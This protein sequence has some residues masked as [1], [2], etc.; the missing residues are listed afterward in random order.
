MAFVHVRC[1]QRWRKERV[2]RAYTCEICN[3]SYNISRP[4]W[5]SIIG[6]RILAAFLALLTIFGIL[7]AMAYIVKVIDLYGFHHTPKPE[8]LDWQKWHGTSQF[9]WLDRFY[10]LV[11]LLIVAF[12]GFIA[13]GIMSCAPVQY[14]WGIAPPSMSMAA[15]DMG[16][17]GD[18]GIVIVFVIA[19]VGFFA[20]LFGVYALVYILLS[21]LLYNAKERVLEVID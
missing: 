5:A 13:V 9:I 18:C 2:E 6:S 10:L 1:L 16:S 12:F 14:D 8:D 19:V 20:A 15:C 11:S 7:L 4:F 3:Y 17:C 21:K